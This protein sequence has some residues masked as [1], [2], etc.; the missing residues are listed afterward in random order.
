MS[1]KE[2]G[3]SLGISDKAVSSYEQSRATPPLGTLQK[4]AKITHKPISYFT[5][6]EE[7]EL[8][9]SIASILLNIEKELG[10][11]KKLIKNEKF[12]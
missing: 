9:F 2:L 4:I 7:S 6:G 8:E 10:E 1:Q 11:V 12:S 5:S 3:D